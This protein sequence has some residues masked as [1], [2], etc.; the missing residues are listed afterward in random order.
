MLPQLPQ[1]TK[2]YASRK[3]WDTWA[4]VCTIYYYKHNMLSLVLCWQCVWRTEPH[5]SSWLTMCLCNTHCHTRSTVLPLVTTTASGVAYISH[6]VQ[7]HQCSQGYTKLIQQIVNHYFTPLPMN[8]RVQ[9]TVQQEQSAGSPV[10]HTICY[11]HLR[12]LH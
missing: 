11:K 8:T 1:T 3:Q 5:N 9:T 4:T 2:N 7:T 6:S 12:A 10:M